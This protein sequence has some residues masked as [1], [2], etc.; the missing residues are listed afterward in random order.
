MNN[1]DK[2]LIK[3]MNKKELAALYS[4]SL[5]ALNRWLEPFKEKIGKERGRTYTPKQVRIIFECLGEP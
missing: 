2:I 3:A 5:T 1:D 4:V